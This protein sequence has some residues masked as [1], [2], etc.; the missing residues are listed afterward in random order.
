MKK[1][2]TRLF[3]LVDD[4]LKALEEER[5]KKQDRVYRFDVFERV[6]SEENL[7]KQSFQRIGEEG[8]IDERLVFRV[9]IT[10]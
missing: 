6:P 9:Q 4:F 2:I 7:Q 5:E 1:D 3:C 10:H 8:K